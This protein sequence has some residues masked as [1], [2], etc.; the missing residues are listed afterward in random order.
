MEKNEIRF[1]PY[2]IHK[3]NSRWDKGLNIIGKTI[4]LLEDN[5]GE[6]FCDLRVGKDF[7]N[8]TQEVQTIKTKIDKLDYT[9]IKNFCSSKD[10]LQ[11]AP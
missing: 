7:L 9:K 4:K 3:I 6:Y 8:K 5:I 1:L 11:P 10:T 2:T